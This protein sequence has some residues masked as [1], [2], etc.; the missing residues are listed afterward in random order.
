MPAARPA[1]DAAGGC[2]VVRVVDGDT[3]DMACPGEGR[4]RARLTG[5][6]TPES[7][8]AGCPQ[9]ADLAAAATRRL[10]A[11]VRQAATVDADLGGTDRYDRRLVGLRLDGRDVGEDAGGRGAGGALSRRA[12]HR[13]VHAAELTPD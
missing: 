1:P 9:E 7:W 10:R 6:D 12:A 13:L 4:F 2:S 5:F 8:N 11:L 3:V